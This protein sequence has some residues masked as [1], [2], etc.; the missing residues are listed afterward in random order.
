MLSDGTFLSR[1]LR[2]AN[3]KSSSVGCKHVGDVVWQGG[4]P[5]TLYPMLAVDAL[6]TVVAASDSCQ[7]SVAGAKGSLT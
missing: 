5:F 2:A 7:G 3:R 4:E 6:P 1:D